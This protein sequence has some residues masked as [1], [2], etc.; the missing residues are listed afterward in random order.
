MIVIPVL[1][2]PVKPVNV[3]TSSIT[4][5]MIISAVPLISASLEFNT[6]LEPLAQRTLIANGIQ[7]LRTVVN[8]LLVRHLNVA[9]GRIVI[10]SL[11]IQNV[12]VIRRILVAW[13]RSVRMLGVGLGILVM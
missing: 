9:L 4:Y 11:M 6:P 12:P 8:S 7:N 1:P 13:R 10:L 5:V 2:I 3:N